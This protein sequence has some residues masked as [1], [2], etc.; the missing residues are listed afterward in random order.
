MMPYRR[1]KGYKE[2][3]EHVTQ[4]I[5]EKEKIWVYPSEDHII[6]SNARMDTKEEDICYLDHL[7]SAIISN[8]VHGSENMAK[9]LCKLL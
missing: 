5:T 1:A 4:I 9:E 3:F 6:Y 7:L 2:I 8:Q